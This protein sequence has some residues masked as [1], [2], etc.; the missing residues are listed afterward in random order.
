LKKDLAQLV[1]LSKFDVEI[2]EF[3]PKIEKENDKLKI[4]LSTVSK[5]NEQIDQLYV[6][7]DE[8]KNKRIKNDIHLKELSDKLNEIDSKSNVVKTEKEIKALQLEEEI[9]KEQINF[10]ND[11]IV[12]LDN[13]IEVKKEELQELKDQLAQEEEEVKELK[14]QVEQTI[15]EFNTTRANIA[16]ER[17]KLFETI[18]SKVLVFYEKIRRWAKETAVVPVKNQACYGCHM[19]LQ[20]RVYFEFIHSDEIKT[21]PNCGRIIYLEEI[22]EEN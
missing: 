18:D 20:D 13:L 7:I 5:L 19:K 3:E 21:C 10:A 8:L 11:E 12:R 1:K 17:S 2:S 6:E 14:A 4:F 22:S 16:Q 9:A 15:E